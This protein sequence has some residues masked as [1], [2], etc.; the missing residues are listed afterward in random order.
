M[1]FLY[2]YIAF[3]LQSE[4]ISNYYEFYLLRTSQEH[5]NENA[6]SSTVTESYTEENERVSDSDDE[7]SDLWKSKFQYL[8]K[9]PK[10]TSSDSSDSCNALL[11]S[12]NLHLKEKSTRTLME[13][14]DIAVFADEATSLARKEMMGLFVSA[15]EEKNKR[16][17]VE[18]VFIA[19]VYSTQSAILLDKVKNILSDNNTDIFKTRC[20]YL[21]GTNA[22]TGEHTSL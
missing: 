3:D 5:H 11:N 9:C 19:T 15:N 21:D 22:M 4:H 1:H 8:E 6:S 7:L 17:I 12:L 2:M 18:F 10:N 20:S 14:D 13:A 16:V